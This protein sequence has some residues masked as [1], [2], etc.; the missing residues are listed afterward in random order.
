ME[1]KRITVDTHT[2]IW[3]LHEPS[4]FLLSARA[5]QVVEDAEALGIIYVPTIVLA[6]A[7]DLADRGR[8]PLPFDQLIELIKRNS[9]Y[10]IIPFD[11]VLLSMAIPLKRLEIHDRLIL[12]TAILT[13]SILVSKDR[14]L[15][16]R[17]AN[18]VW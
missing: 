16:S 12:A 11:T 9:S 14:T 10:R 4:Q 5:L 18:V 3:Y 2:L 15:A 8:I 7:L 6:E 17:G 1:V 13:N